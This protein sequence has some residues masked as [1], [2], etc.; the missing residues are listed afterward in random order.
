MN[1]PRGWPYRFCDIFKE[2][3]DV[4]IRS[5]FDLRDLRNRE[6]RAIPN[7][8]RVFFRNLAKLSHRL[9]GEHFSLEPNLEFAFVRP[10]LAHFWPGITI[11]HFRKI[12]ASGEREKRFMYKKVV[13]SKLAQRLAIRGRRPELFRGY[14]FCPN[15]GKRGRA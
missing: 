12:K 5:L 3:D 13:R 14:R 6:P 9:A 10:D 2:G 4:V 7:F 8:R 15:F 11:D 1:P